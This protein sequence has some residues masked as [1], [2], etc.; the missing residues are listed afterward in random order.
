[1]L[2]AVPVWARVCTPAQRRP[3][4]P[5]DGRRQAGRGRPRRTRPAARREMPPG[6]ASPH[7]SRVPALR[8]GV[9]GAAG[10]C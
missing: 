7:R 2:G 6:T 9:D 3:A 5:G 10:G 8:R 4:A 1:M